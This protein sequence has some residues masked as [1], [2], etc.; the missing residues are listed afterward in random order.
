MLYLKYICK[1][2]GGNFDITA[3]EEVTMEINHTFPI[4]HVIIQFKT[5]DIY[6]NEFEIYM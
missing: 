4:Y 6:R 2:T 5:Y 3:L 1:D